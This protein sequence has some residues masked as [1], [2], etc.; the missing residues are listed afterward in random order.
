MLSGDASESI[1][2]TQ[3]HL[4]NFKF[5]SIA[6]MQATW[7]LVRPDEAFLKV[8]E[9]KRQLTTALE[10][11]FNVAVTFKNVSQRALKINATRMELKLADEHNEKVDV[12]NGSG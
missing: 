3:E 8:F 9:N 1:V 4:T 7:S 6:P 11:E 10:Q 5:E 12:V 2:F